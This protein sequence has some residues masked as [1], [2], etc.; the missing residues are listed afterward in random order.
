MSLTWTFYIVA[1]LRVAGDEDTVGG[2]RDPSA[3]RPPAAI[4]PMAT[5]VC[6]AHL[7]S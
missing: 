7:V 3:V 6:A 1:A 2:R 5:A 4:R